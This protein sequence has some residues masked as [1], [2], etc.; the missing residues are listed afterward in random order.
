MK[1][2]FQRTLLSGKSFAFSA[3][4]LFFASFQSNLQ[5]ADIRLV[6]PGKNGQ[7]INEYGLPE[8]PPK[9]WAFLPAGD[10]ACTRKVTA[11][12]PCWRVQIRK[13]NRMQSIGLWA[14]Q[15]H[16]QAA[17]GEVTLMRANP[18]YEKKK[19]SAERSRA[20]KQA[21]YVV[22]FEQEVRKYLHFHPL[23]E[24][25]AEK[26]AHLVTVHATPVGS[27]TVARTSRIPVEE[28]AAR[29]VIAW[30]RHQT[31]NYD[32]LKIARIKGERRQVRRQLAEQSVAL[33]RA[34]RRGEPVPP[35]CPLRKALMTP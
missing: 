32:H 22:D 29:A 24:K 15:A 7:V 3:G 1:T 16:I 17:Q 5:M 13:R 35:D 33:L 25:Q 9:D 6:S 20:K 19:A 30:M 28:R 26:M 21:N 2:V 10:A 12:G 14:P 4:C 34:Y 27:G 11:M 23:Y 31:T 8:S 18:D